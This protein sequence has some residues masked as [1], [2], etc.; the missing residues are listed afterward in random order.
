MSHN[1]GGFRNGSGRKKK[2]L[3]LGFSGNTIKFSVNMPI[4][5][6]NWIMTKE[7]KN[8]NDKLINYLTEIMKKG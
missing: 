6:E 2:G 3:K 4:E 5:I 1:H 8:R 7:G